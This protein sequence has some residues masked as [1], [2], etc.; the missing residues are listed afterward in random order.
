MAMTISPWKF[1]LYPELRRYE[2][3]AQAQ[4]LRSGA[5]ISSFILAIPLLLVLAGPFYVRRIRRALKAQLMTEQRAGGV[6]E[7][8]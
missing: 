3:G 8:R 2:P 6:H 7:K 4:A 5:A 1:V